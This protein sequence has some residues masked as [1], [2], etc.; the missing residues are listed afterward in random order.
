MTL[1]H[2]MLSNEERAEYARRLAALTNA[3]RSEMTA[4][5]YLRIASREPSAVRSIKAVVTSLYYRL[6]EVKEM[7]TG[8]MGLKL[9]AEEDWSRF[10]RTLR[11][12]YGCE[13]IDWST[14]PAVPEFQWVRLI[15]ETD[16]YPLYCDAP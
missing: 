7:L 15:A 8:A 14:F 5:R 2:D 16:I 6:L 4:D 13:K 11:A 1:A 10:F 12:E 9:R 3:A